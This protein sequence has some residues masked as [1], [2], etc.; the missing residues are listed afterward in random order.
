MNRSSCSCQ[1]SSNWVRLTRLP[2]LVC[3]Q[4]KQMR[5]E[6]MTCRIESVL[7]PY[8]FFPNS[9]DSMNFP[10]PKSVS[11]PGRLTKWYSRPFCSCILG[12]LVV[13]KFK[14]KDFRTCLQ[15]SFTTNGHFKSMNVRGIATANFSGSMDRSLRRNSS[16]PLF[17]GPIRAMGRLRLAGWW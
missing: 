13:S 11:K 17:V 3:R 4:S 9:P 6:L 5:P 15:K 2:T 8:K 12:L 1:N 14:K 7:V 16:C 10:A